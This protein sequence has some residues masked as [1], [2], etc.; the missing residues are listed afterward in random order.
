[1]ALLKIKEQE[2]TNKFKLCL[3]ELLGKQSQFDTIFKLIGTEQ[4]LRSAL[5]YLNKELLYKY[6]LDDDSQYFASK[7]VNKLKEGINKLCEKN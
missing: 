5:N 7:G 3:G 4:K 2:N 6:V 1:M